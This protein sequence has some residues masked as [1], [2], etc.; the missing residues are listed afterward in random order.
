MTAK[1]EGVLDF[2]GGRATVLRLVT[3]REPG[4]KADEPEEVSVA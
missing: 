2:V 4:G 3:G 1:G